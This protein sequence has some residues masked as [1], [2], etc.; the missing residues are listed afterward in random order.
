MATTYQIRV[1]RTLLRLGPDQIAAVSAAIDALGDEEI[2][3]LDAVLAKADKAILRSADLMAGRTGGVESKAKDN[4][5]A[6][7][8]YVATLTGLPDPTLGFVGSV[9]TPAPALD[10]LGYG[11]GSYGFPPDLGL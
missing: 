1:V 4:R 3:A 7:I 11:P 8:T 5:A 2:D 6:Y 9:D 10:L